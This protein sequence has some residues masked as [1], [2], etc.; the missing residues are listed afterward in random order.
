M[1]ESPKRLHGLKG[2][3]QVSRTRS[4]CCPTASSEKSAVGESSW[5]HG[6]G[7]D[8]L[9]NITSTSPCCCATQDIWGIVGT[10][11]AVAGGAELVQ[12]S[13]GHEQP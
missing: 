13:G 3:L 10:R 7:T 5:G 6:H 1:K 2:W 4:H 12:L 8:H 9:P 11:E